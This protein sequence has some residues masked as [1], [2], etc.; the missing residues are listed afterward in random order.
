MF[1]KFV[2]KKKRICAIE[3]CTLPRLICVYKYR[4][5]FRSTIANSTENRIVSP[6][7]SSRGA[8]REMVEHLKL[9]KDQVRSRKIQLIHNI[10]S[11]KLPVLRAVSCSDFLHCPHFPWHNYYQLIKSF[12]QFTL[13]A[14]DSLRGLR[15]RSVSRSA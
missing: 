2:T 14:G 11:H 10:H 8:F 15:C 1:C 7:E 6:L 5:V 12:H 9:M 3:K 13:Y 4:C